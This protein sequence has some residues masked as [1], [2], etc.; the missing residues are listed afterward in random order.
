MLANN[1]NTSPYD[2]YG[3][4]RATAGLS[5]SYNNGAS[6]LPVSLVSAPTA[7]VVYELALTISPTAVKGYVNGV[8]TTSGSG[9]TAIAYGATAEIVMGPYNGST[10]NSNAATSL[11]MVY[12]KALDSA[13]IAAIYKLNSRKSNE[14][15]RYIKRPWSTGVAAIISS[16]LLKRRRMLM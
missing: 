13:T 3:F 9:V 2:G 6:Y 15:I 5:Y 12:N 16:L 7:N 14:L 1:T 4:F 11:A 10:G 8:A